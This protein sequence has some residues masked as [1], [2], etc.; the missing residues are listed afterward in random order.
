M[1]REKSVYVQEMSF[2]HFEY[3][4]PIDAWIQ[5]CVC[6]YMFMWGMLVCVCYCTSVRLEDISTRLYKLVRCCKARL[7][8]PQAFRD[9]PISL[10]RCTGI[11]K[12]WC[13]AFGFCV[14]SGD[15]HTG[16][17]ACSVSALTH[18]AS[19]LPILSSVVL[20]SCPPRLP[21]ELSCV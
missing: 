13:I 8:G 7:P 2:F 5:G 9:L 19:T 12:E 4:L 21:K 3:F 17:Q 10:C 1:V 16:H 18:W 6:V 11:T 14:G 15:P 20:F